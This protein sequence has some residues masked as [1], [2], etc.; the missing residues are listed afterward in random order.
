MSAFVR[1]QLQQVYNADMEPPYEVQHYPLRARV[2]RWCRILARERWLNEPED[3]RT[4]KSAVE[5][6]DDIEREGLV[7]NE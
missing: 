2:R 1:S 6:A 7:I 4:W 3:K 5:L